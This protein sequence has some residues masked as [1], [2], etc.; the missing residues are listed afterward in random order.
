MGPFA[1]QIDRWL[2]D[3]LNNPP[4]QHLTARR[5]YQLPEERPEFDAAESTVRRFVRLRRQLLR[6]PELFIPLAY[7][8]GMDARCDF[9]EGLIV[10]NQARV[11]AQLFCMRLCYSKRPFVMA[12]PH[13]RRE[14]FF[15]GHQAAFAFYQGVPHRIWYDNLKPAVKRILEG[16]NREEQADFIALRSHYL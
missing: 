3:D 15:E 13:R 14:A 7:E 2:A 5:I 1:E 6:P 12:F 8:P 16:R 9:G 4:K 10:L 11:T